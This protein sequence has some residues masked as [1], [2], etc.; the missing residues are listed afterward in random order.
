MSLNL[1]ICPS[2]HPF[3]YLPIHLSNL[4][5]SIYLHIYQFPLTSTSRET[6]VTIFQ[7]SGPH[8]PPPP[9][10][11]SD[12]TDLPTPNPKSVKSRGMWGRCLPEI[13]SLRRNLSPFFTLYLN[14]KTLFC[15]FL[16]PFLNVPLHSSSSSSL[17]S[18]PLFLL[19]RL[20]SYFF[21]PFFSFFNPHHLVFFVFLSSL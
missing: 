11:P 20:Y 12:L 21:P 18:F 4:Y 2:I 13:L 6:V 16:I 5:L 14:V 8:H 15:S 3:I 19:T 17:F 1:S 10:T 9:P 7:Q